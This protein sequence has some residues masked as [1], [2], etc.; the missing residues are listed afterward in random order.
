MLSDN[1]QDG[2]FDLARWLLN[3]QTDSSV[4]HRVGTIPIAYGDRLI[5]VDVAMFEQRRQAVRDGLQ[6]RQLVF[7]LNTETLGRVEIAAAM[8][9]QHIRIRVTSDSLHASETIA[10]H[11]SELRQVLSDY[12]WQPDEV[13]YEVRDAAQGQNVARTVVEHVVRQDSLS[14]LI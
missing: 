2:K 5:E 6:H 4:A 1:P 12:G 8:A 3:V 11:M 10:S 7:V 14:F 9:D 13:V